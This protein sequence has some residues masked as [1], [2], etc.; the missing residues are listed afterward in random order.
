MLT[1][2]TWIAGS[3]AACAQSA[4]EA[5]R[6]RTPYKYGKLVVAAS[7]EEG[8]FDGRSVDCPFVFHHNGR[9]YMTYVGWDGTG[10]QTGLASSTDLTSWQKEGCIL[11]RDASNPVTRYNIA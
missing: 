6:Y 2:R 4:D 5:A 3:M 8:A 11:K 10:Y 9:F 1:R 7:S